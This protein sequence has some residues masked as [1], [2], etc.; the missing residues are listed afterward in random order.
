MVRLS[1]K[2]SYIQPKQAEKPQEYGRGNRVRKAVNYCDDLTD[3]QFMK[4]CED[5]DDL[6]ELDSSLVAVPRRKKGRGR[7][8]E[9]SKSVKSGENND[10]DY[11]DD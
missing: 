3:E 5:D 6:E 10:D 4:M 7:F 9:S 8:K 1:S 2:H 11:G